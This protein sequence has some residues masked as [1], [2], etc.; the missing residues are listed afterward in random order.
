MEIEESF[1]SLWC[2]NNERMSKR[3]SQIRIRQKTVA[4]RVMAILKP[5]RQESGVTIRVADL[6]QMLKENPRRKMGVFVY[7]K[8]L[9]VKLSSISIIIVGELLR[10]SNLEGW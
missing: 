8:F 6:N 5:D 4:R 2:S 9:S 7:V 1:I 10:L 3:R